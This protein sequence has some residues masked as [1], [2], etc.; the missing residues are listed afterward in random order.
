MIENWSQTGYYNV[1]AECVDIEPEQL[2]NNWTETWIQQSS[3]KTPQ[4]I[5]SQVVT[6]KSQ[7]IEVSVSQYGCFRSADSPNR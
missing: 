5:S 3:Q 6:Q 2:Q 7:Q 1:K 4:S